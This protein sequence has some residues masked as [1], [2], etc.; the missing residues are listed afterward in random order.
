[1]IDSHYLIEYR[2]KIYPQLYQNTSFNQNQ[3]LNLILKKY[4]LNSWGSRCTQMNLIMIL[5]LFLDMELMLILKFLLLFQSCSWL[6]RSLLSLFISF[7]LVSLDI[8]AKIFWLN[9]QLLILEHLMLFVKRHYF[10]DNNL[11]LLV[12]KELF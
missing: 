5:F 9:Y 1:M 6:L 7:I 12:R 8:E 2:Y 4:C 3:I 11:L 10:L